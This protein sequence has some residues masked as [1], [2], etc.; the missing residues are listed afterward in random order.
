MSWMSFHVLA[1]STHSTL[2]GSTWE[3]WGIRDWSSSRT[4]M[5]GIFTSTGHPQKETESIERRATGWPSA[6]KKD[7]EERA[8]GLVA[9]VPVMIPG[10]CVLLCAGRDAARS[11]RARRLPGHPH[12][13]PELQVLQYG[14]HAGRDAG[15]WPVRNAVGGGGFWQPGLRRPASC[16]SANLECRATTKREERVSTWDGQWRGCRSRQW[17]RLSLSC[18]TSRGS[19]TLCLGCGRR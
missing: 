3:C 11:L 2:R 17:A 12:W 4:G 10:S 16:Q 8:N 14:L 5:H 13:S 9:G 19:S 15:S 18:A 6:E 7:A 1:D